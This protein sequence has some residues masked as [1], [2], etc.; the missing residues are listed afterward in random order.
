MKKIRKTYIY[1][2][3]LAHFSK[4]S[5]QCSHWDE[6]WSTIDIAKEYSWADNGALGVFKPAFLHYLP[7]EGL[8]LEAGCG[9][10]KIVRALLHYGYQVIG[11]DFAL[12]T[13]SAAKK[14]WDEAPF[15]GCDIRHLPIARKTIKAVLLLGVIE[16][17]EDPWVVLQD[18]VRVLCDG[19]LL[20]LVV[21]FQ[22]WI[23]RRY[24]LRRV[25]PSRDCEVDFD[26][27]IF[28]PEEINKNLSGYGFKVLTQFSTSGYSGFVESYPKFDEWFR[29][30]PYANHLINLTNR[31]R[32]LGRIFGHV[33]HTVACKC[34]NE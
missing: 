34:P 20:Y 17:F 27:F 13:L 15:V 31:S 23:R 33:I 25:Y 24:M 18:S 28:T 32:W 19:G 29:K 30:L 26:Q 12:Q 8:I 2:Q 3:R 6:H 7:K 11:I 5:D 10:G 4:K 22:N 21:P 14:I 1:R 9:Y 16:H